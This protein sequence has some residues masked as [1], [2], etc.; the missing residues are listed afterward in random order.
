MSAKSPIPPP[1]PPPVGVIV[2]AVVVVVV[3]V[4]F[5]D[6][7]VEDEPGVAMRL[8][9]AFKAADIL[10]PPDE[11]ESEEVELDLPA[12]DVMVTAGLPPPAPAAEARP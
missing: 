11:D 7:A 3:E 4:V 9:A 2:V 12:L 1:P 5:E 8:V 6:D 10:D